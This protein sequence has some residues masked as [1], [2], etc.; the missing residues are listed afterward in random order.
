MFAAIIP[1][2]KEPIANPESNKTT[3]YVA[4]AVP[5]LFIGEDLIAID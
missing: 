4:V 3:K 1:N 5:R 2:K